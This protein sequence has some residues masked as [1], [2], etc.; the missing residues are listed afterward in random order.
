MYLY[1]STYNLHVDIWRDLN[2]LI[3]ISFLVN[4]ICFPINA[5]D[6]SQNVY[7]E[8][9]ESIIISLEILYWLFL[10]QCSNSQLSNDKVSEEK[11]F[12]G[13]A[14][15]FIKVFRLNISHFP[16]MF[17]LRWITLHFKECSSHL[18][19]RIPGYNMPLRRVLNKGYLS[20]IKYMSIINFPWNSYQM[21]PKVFK[22]KCWKVLY[23]KI[24]LMYFT[25]W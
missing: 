18:F 24:L 10:F 2:S 1:C 12:F 4:I 21:F 6:F 23:R 5:N 15:N 9:I 13:I 16:I 8:K 19:H 20:Y 25:S 17:M 3:I 7:S 11:I 22:Q 14:N